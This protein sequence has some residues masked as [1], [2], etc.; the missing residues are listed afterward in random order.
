MNSIGNSLKRTIFPKGTKSRY[1]CKVHPQT[2]KRKIG[3]VL[4]TC[5]CGWVGA[6]TAVGG[7]TGFYAFS[8]YSFEPRDYPRYYEYKHLPIVS[9]FIIRSE[10]IMLGALLFGTMSSGILTPVG[11]VI[12]R[13][14]KKPRKK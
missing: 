14:I 5:Y 12:R 1:Y 9:R 3:T 8:P 2:N 6:W 7:I 10:A 4:L 11:M 13:E